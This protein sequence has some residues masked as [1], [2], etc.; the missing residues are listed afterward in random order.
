MTES[1][2][3]R[4]KLA[5]GFLQEASQDVTLKRWRSTMDN[6]QLA[7]ENA[8]KG[9]LA[10]IGPVGRTHQ[11]APLLREAVQ[12][13][14]FPEP[15]PQPVLRLAELAEQLGLDVH[16]QTDYGNEAEGLTPWDLFDEADAQQALAMAQEAVS[17]AQAI[18][19]QLAEEGNA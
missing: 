13:E 10:L 9:V 1:L 2:E 16:I 19:Q 18:A 15:H 6:A 14:L 5:A 12:K 11:P 7:V 17:L 8:A 4:L 3:Y